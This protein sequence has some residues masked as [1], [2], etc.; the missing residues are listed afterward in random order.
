MGRVSLIL[1]VASP[2]V[3]SARLVDRFRAGFESADHKVEVL[4]V[5]DPDTVVPD[6]PI[7]E[8]FTW[9]TAGWTG[10]APAAM[11][12]INEAGGEYLVVLDP[13]SGYDPDDLETMVAPLVAGSADFV[14]ARRAQGPGK[15]L[16]GIAGS[17][18]ALFT[19]PLLGVSDPLAGLLALT[20]AQAQELMVAFDPVGARFTL[21]LLFRSRGRIV[22][23]PIRTL[24]ASPSL[25]V[26]LDDLRHV[27]RLADD[28]FGN[29]SRLIQ[30][31]VVGASGMVVDLSCYAL[32]QLVFSQTYLSLVRAPL[33][34]GALDLAVAGALAIALALTWNFSLNRRL[35]FNYA[36]SGSIPRQF[37]TY[38]LSN[39]LGIGL[40]FSLR[41]YLPVHVG[42]FARHRLAAALVGIVAA[43]GISFSMARWLVFGRRA[44]LSMEEAGDETRE[45]VAQTTPAG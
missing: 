9:V 24:A 2:S 23:M 29:G 42:F 37:L 28:R 31:C 1:P 36:R 15:G 7:G 6:E 41:L 10:L 18:T 39:A 34:G 40:S 43:T 25:A 35:T 13:T 30:F 38:V 17:A 12:G 45:K 11:A 33:V 21:D 14:V 3:L 5:L 32:F 22:E 16:R 44:G 8:G 27:K 26:R 20:Q 19:R 4:G